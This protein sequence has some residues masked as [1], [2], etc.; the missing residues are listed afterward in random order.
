MVNNESAQI[1]RMF[2]SQFNEF[3]KNP[4]IDLTPA[5][6]MSAIEEVNAWVLPTI[7]SGVYKCGNATSQAAYDEVR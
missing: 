2:N 5:D 1:M 7:N 3:A 4:H 6:L